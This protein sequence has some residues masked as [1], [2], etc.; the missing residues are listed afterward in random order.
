MW[1][2]IVERGRPQMTKWRMRIACWVTK[3]TDTHTVDVILLL[4]YRKNGYANAPQCYVLSTQLLLC[5]LLSL[6]Q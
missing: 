1:K 2:N 4:S 6:S 3:A 5:V